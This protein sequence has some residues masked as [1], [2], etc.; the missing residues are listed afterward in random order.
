MRI[1]SLTL[2]N[3]KRFTDLEIGNLSENAKLVLLVGS[4][5]SGKSSIFDA[6]N[7]LSPEQYNVRTEIAAYDRKDAD[8]PFSIEAKLQDRKSTRLNSSHG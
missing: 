8:K 4:N 2:K 3:F 5:G 1:A 6:F 7:F